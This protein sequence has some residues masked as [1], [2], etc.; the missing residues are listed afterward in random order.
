MKLRR[1][2]FIKLAS[3][4][5]L[6]TVILVLA[7]FYNLKYQTPIVP[8]SSKMITTVSPSSKIITTAPLEQLSYG[9]PVRINIPA[10]NIDTTFENVGVT[11]EGAMA[12]PKNIDEIGWYDLGTRPGNS[13]SAVIAGH[14]GYKKGQAAAFNNIYKLIKGDKILV[15]DSNGNT[16]SFV[17]KEIKSY[18]P[19]ANTAEVFISNDGVS[20]LNL[21]TCEGVW[22]ETTKS[23]SGR[24]VIFADKDK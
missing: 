23:Y 11:P 17:V 18:D 2:Q 19:Q 13:G 15:I 7:F 12:M 10:I 14:Y 20:H 8:P 3:G 16:I 9:E 1:K 4:I 22:N 6:F 21:I 24:L 5:I